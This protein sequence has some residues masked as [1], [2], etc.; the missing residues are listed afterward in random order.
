MKKSAYSVAVIGATGLVGREI[1][2]ALDQRAFPIADLGLYASVRSAGDD[3]RCGG[4]SACVELLEGARFDGTDIAFFA[5]GEQVSAE[6]AAR[7]CESGAVV[8][9]LS[10]L[11][12]DD[13][14]VPLVVPEV[15]AAHLADYSGR[16]IVASPDA[17]AIALSVLLQP[18]HA[19]AGVARVV[20]TSLEPASGAGQPG[21]DELQR[22]TLA[23]MSGRSAEAELF[24]RRLAFNIVP[25]IG[26]LLAGGASRDEQQ[27]V[28]AVQRVLDTLGLPVSVTRVR[29]PIFFGT[30]L[31]VNVET[32]GRL[33]AATAREILR[34]APGVLLQDDATAPQYSTPADA[35]GQ[36]AVCIGRIRG[37]ESANVLDVW[38]AIDNTRKGAAVNAVQIAELLIRDYL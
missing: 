13:P 31:L 9:D 30:A 21:I 11:F 17:P 25:Q 1:I 19:V 37:D 2:A 5:A 4:V 26:E 27:T 24:P 33:S 35:V 16:D 6:W 20:A 34:A 7:A 3:V 22:Q 15:N 12:V 18:L 32:T 23:L 38:L 14:D 8:V 10:Q 29:A 28:R 36:D